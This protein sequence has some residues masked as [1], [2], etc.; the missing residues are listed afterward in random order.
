MSS[1]LDILVNKVRENVTRATEIN[2]NIEQGLT[3]LC[4]F[5]E[6]KRKERLANA[7]DDLI[8]KMNQM[9]HKMGNTLNSLEKIIKRNWLH[10]LGKLRGYNRS[11]KALLL[12]NVFGRAER[13]HRIMMRD[14]INRNRQ[15]GLQDGHYIQ[16]SHL[17]KEIM[18]RKDFNERGRAFGDMRQ[19]FLDEKNQINRGGQK[20]G[21]LE[22]IFW[23]KKQRTFDHIMDL[24]FKERKRNLRLKKMCEILDRHEAKKAFAT[25]FGSILNDVK[26]RER[27]NNLIKSVL[28]RMMFKKKA[29]I[30]DAMRR[31]TINAI[32]KW[33]IGDVLDHMH[34]LTDKSEFEGLTELLALARIMKGKDAESRRRKAAD[35][36]LMAVH[37]VQTRY[38]NEGYDRVKA[39]SDFILHTL[40][41][42]SNNKWDMI[43]LQALIAKRKKNALLIACGVVKAEGVMG[44]NQWNLEQRKQAF[45]TLKRYLWEQ[46]RYGDKKSGIC[47]LIGTM[48]GISQRKTQ[49]GFEVIK[50]SCTGNKLVATD[51][52]QRIQ[53]TS[54]SLFSMINTNYDVDFSNKMRIQ[55]GEVSSPLGQSKL[56]QKSTGR[57][58]RPQYSTSR[59]YNTRFGGR[60]QRIQKSGIGAGTYTTIERTSVGRDGG[61]VGG[62]ETIVESRGGNGG[63]SRMVSGRNGGYEKIVESRVVSGGGSGRMVSGGGRMVS[64]GGRIVSGGD[65]GAYETVVTKKVS[66]SS[67]S[68]RY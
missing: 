61:L 46:K 42:E 50:A 8:S 22:E 23:R 53:R 52:Q 32:S 38:L 43:R 7:Y 58:N 2:P 21:D 3:G 66:S 34:M 31:M 9:E 28:E 11:M 56:I 29:K 20:L 19:I 49:S 47:M 51:L 13:N 1:S 10:N 45:R 14:F 27:N 54:G 16:F 68:R 60:N 40:Y 62:Y 67:R 41:S 48:N 26:N 30:R 6:F 65:G 57:R 63:G 5:T 37:R 25:G 39:Y 17:L 55:K 18:Q 44:Q 4:K 36:L 64:G 33:G 35:G 15:G 24:L 12:R 59:S